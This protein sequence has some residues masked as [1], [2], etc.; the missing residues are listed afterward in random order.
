[1]GRKSEHVA[2]QKYRVICLEYT[3][4]SNRASVAPSCTALSLCG[5]I[6]YDRQWRSHNELGSKCR[7][8][9][10]CSSVAEGI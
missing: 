6:S 4:T 3:R 2:Q 7:N 1:V 8:Y 9:R 5:P 10:V